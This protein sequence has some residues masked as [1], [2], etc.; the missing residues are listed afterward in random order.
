MNMRLLAGQLAAFLYNC[1]ISRVPSRTI[2]HL[3]LRGWLGGFGAGSGVQMGCQFLNGRKV[4]LGERNS[5]NSGC[6]FDGRT[7]PI[8]TGADVSIGPKATILTLSHDP[9]SDD[10][11]DK[12]GAVVVGDHAWIA[13]GAVILPGVTIGEGAVV[14]AGAVVTKDVA[15]Y[16]IVGGNPA[17][18][19]GQRN[20][21][22]R[23]RLAYRP[24]LN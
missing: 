19:I 18:E 13:Y 16:T 17:R 24:W 4:Q 15:P 20:R 2:R 23:Y 5:I 9:Q 12:G 10:F 7:F 21:E 8:R 11:A 6:L 22:L 1:V 14:A 3:F